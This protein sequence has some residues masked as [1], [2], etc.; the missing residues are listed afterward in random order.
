LGKGFNRVCWN[1]DASFINLANAKVCT[2]ETEFSRLAIQLQRPLRVRRGSLVSIAKL[3]CHPEEAFGQCSPG[4][5]V[6]AAQ[7]A[8]STNWKEAAGDDVYSAW[9]HQ[10][11]FRQLSSSVGAITTLHEQQQLMCHSNASTPDHDHHGC[12]RPYELDH[13]AE[14]AC[15][16]YG[17]LELLALRGKARKLCIKLR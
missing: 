7:C 5:H 16:C 3:F 8:L 15:T 2:R 11:I 17:S 9:M 4:S 1:T 14:S 12:F 10:I 13:A 6:E